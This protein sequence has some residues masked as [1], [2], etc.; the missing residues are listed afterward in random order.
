MRVEF[1]RFNQWNGVVR[2]QLRRLTLREGDLWYAVN[3][4]PTSPTWVIFVRSRPVA[5]GTLLEKYE[6]YDDAPRD[7]SF[8]VYTQRAYRRRGY[9]KLLYKR[10]MTWKKRYKKRWTDTVFVHDSI[11]DGFFQA[12]R[13]EDWC[14]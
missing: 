9:G 13:P 6:E 5:W 11:S 4:E 12:V 7:Y 14:E 8:M 2:R 10:A 1:R 3:K